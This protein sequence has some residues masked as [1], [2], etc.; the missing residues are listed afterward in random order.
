LVG[1]ALGRL[2]GFTLPA[3]MVLDVAVSIASTVV[4]LRE[5]DVLLPNPAPDFHL[6]A[7]DQLALIGNGSQVGVAE[8]LLVAGLD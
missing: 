1:A 8:S 7:G 3:S 4:L 5:F 6:R 2:L